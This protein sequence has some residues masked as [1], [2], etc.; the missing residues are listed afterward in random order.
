[1][2]KVVQISSQFYVVYEENEKFRIID[3]PFLEEW[4]AVSYARVNDI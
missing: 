1:M 4:Q 3:G 2:L